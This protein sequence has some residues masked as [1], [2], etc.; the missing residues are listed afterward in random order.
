MS[1]E[2]TE[3]ITTKAEL[4]NE[5]S[6]P[7]PED[8]DFAAELDGD[9]MVLGAA[10]KMGPALVRRIMRASDQAGV[11]RT[12]YAVSRYSNPEDKS[13]LES[14]GAETIQADLLEQG[15]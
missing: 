11:N 5:L 8:I 12:V 15:A 4:S 9:M 2:S 13:R 6:R 7:Y 3:T 14:W 1:D 10:G